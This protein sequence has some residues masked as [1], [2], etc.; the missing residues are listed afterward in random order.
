MTHKGVISGSL[1]DKI[2]HLFIKNEKVYIDELDKIVSIGDVFKSTE[3]SVVYNI[4][5][6]EII[7]DEKSMESLINAERNKKKYNE[8]KRQ[9]EIE[10]EN[11]QNKKW[12]HFFKK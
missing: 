11:K 6:Y 10:N 9:K 3:G 1:F 7:E 5:N 4:Y 2:K 8:E 12:Y